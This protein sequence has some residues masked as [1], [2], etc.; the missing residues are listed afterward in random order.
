LFLPKKSIKS[1]LIK[2]NNPDEKTTNHHKSSIVAHVCLVTYCK[3]SK[4]KSTDNT[5][6]VLIYVSDNLK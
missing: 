1:N 3:I 5:T 2:G 6:K 4:A